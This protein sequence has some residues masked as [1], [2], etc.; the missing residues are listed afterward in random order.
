MTNE[1]E[2][3][4]VKQEDSPSGK[5]STPW[6]MHVLAVAAVVWTLCLSLN[7]IYLNLGLRFTFFSLLRPFSPQW[8]NVPFAE[9]GFACAMIVIYMAVGHL[10]VACFEI[11][12]PRLMRLVLDYVFGLGAMTILIELLTMA[13]QL[14]RLQ[15]IA[16]FAVTIVALWRMAYLR[17]SRRGEAD[18]PHADMRFVRGSR[19]SLARQA[20]RES[21]LPLSGFWAR[22]TFGLLFGLTAVIT[23]LT[24]YYGVFFAETYWDSLILYLGYAR[25]TYL[26][27]AFPFKAVA[28]VG[29]GLGANYPHLYPLMTATSAQ[30]WGSWHDVFGQVAPPWCGLLTTLV[31]Y[32]T[33]LE[34][35]RNRLISAATALLFRLTWYS[36]AYTTWAS[37][38]A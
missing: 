35:S 16:L 37:D 19:A 17:A 28:Q 8:A 24:F 5:T 21:L 4:A 15:L 18:P 9:I 33:V 20:F 10:L 26:Q 31:V 32:Y 14:Y 36:I 29:Y 34:M 30:L 23:L 27:H 12:V 13:H 1:E 2:S 11:H 25:M 7:F 6:L 22:L 3:A 38:Y